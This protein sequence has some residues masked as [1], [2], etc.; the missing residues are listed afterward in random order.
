MRIAACFCL[1]LGFVLVALSVRVQDVNVQH[2]PEIRSG[3]TTPAEALRARMINAQF[4]KDIS[5]LSGLCASVPAD[6]E[7]LK[8][9]I[10]P[11]D[12][13]EKLK[14]VERLSKRVREQLTP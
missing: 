12:I 9:G 2:P 10:L 6:M 8:R 11:K 14:K 1:F 7:E 13:A 3:Q 4:Q 5:E